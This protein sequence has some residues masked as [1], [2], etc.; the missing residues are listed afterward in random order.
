MFELNKKKALVAGGAGYLGLPVSMK[1]AE[2]GAEVVIADYNAEA[3]ERAASEIKKKLPGAGVLW[4]EMDVS[5]EESI[6]N[7][8]QRAAGKPGRVDIMV[9]LAA[10]GSGKGI[11]EITPGEFDRTLHVNLTGGF[12]LARE[13]SG[14]MTDGGSIIL[15]SSMYGRVAPDP[16]IYEEPMKPN[17]LDYGAAKAGIEQLVRYLAVSWG[18][19]GIRVNAIAPGPFPDAEKP[20]CLKDEGF[21]SFVERLCGKVPMGRVGRREETAGAA[22]F[23]SSDEA[24]FITG[25]TIVIDGGWTCW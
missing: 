7:G 9:N 23:L 19:K 25:H 20:S 6:K 13:C 5:N 2:Q 24:S 8:V 17:P 22:V 3:A 16:G 1:L 14:Y 18:G 12:V 15:Y 21:M 11:D 10:A 4:V